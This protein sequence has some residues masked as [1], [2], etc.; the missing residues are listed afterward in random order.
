MGPFLVYVRGLPETPS[1]VEVNARSGPAK[2]YDI[3][4]KVAVG[5]GQLAVQDVR[6]DEAQENYQGKVYQWLRVALPNGQTGWMRDDLIEVV[7]DGLAFG[8]GNVGVQTFA[9]TLT[10][11]PPP[12]VAIPAPVVVPAAPAFT[13]PPISISADVPA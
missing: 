5:T 3:V 11:T 4:C 7:G 10:R 9:F 12:P 6:P 1:I 2:N 13:A 8:Y